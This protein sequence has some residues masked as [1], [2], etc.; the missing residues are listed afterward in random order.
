MKKILTIYKE[1]YPW[2]VRI[3]KLALQFSKENESYI[4]ARNNN[5]E[6]SEEKIGKLNVLRIK[7][8]TTLPKIINKVLQLA[9]WFNP[10]WIYKIYCSAR[11]YKINLIVV[12]DL[13]LAPAAILASKALRIKCVL[14]MAECYPLMYKSICQE[15]N[16]PTTWII[17]NP[18]I[19]TL[20]ERICLKYLDHTWTMIEESE[21]RLLSFGIP[22]EK[23][24]IVSNTPSTTNLLE[25][26]HKGNELRIV[27][28]G[29]VTKLRGLDLL[30]FGIHEFI[31]QHGKT[32]QIQLDIIGKGEEIPYIQSLIKSLDLE[33]NITVHGWLDHSEASKIFN[34]AN[35][36]ALTYRK[37][38]HWDHTIPN[39]IFDYMKAGMPVLCTDIEP[40]MRII[41]AENCG[42]QTALSDESIA[43]ALHTLSDPDLRSAFG[44]NGQKAVAERYNWE[45]ECLKIDRTL[46]ELL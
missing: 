35:V 15:S 36:G 16:N 18:T 40:I 42:I 46:R 20:K 23:V 8:F 9:L 1:E 6:P 19:A 24:S 22:K 11:D 29:F 5:N 28:M 45:H 4:L 31:R 14:D 10:V 37:C 25:K 27:Y 44:R 30:I 2:D 13:P 21:S 7:Y 38:P 39:K 12:R 34:N 32:L 33:K 17:K 3:E 43:S 26:S 41:K